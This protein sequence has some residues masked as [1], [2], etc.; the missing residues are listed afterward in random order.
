[1]STNQLVFDGQPFQIPRRSL[2]ARCELFL[3]KPNLFS[4]PYQVRSQASETSFRVFLVEMEGART[5]I[6]M[7]NVLDLD[8]LTK[9][10]Q[11]VELGRQ[12]AE[13]VSQQHHIDVIRL[14][15]A[16]ADLRRRLAEANG[17]LRAE[18]N[19]QLEALRGAIG[20]IEKKQ[21]HEHKN[22][23]GLREAVGKV[24]RQM[25]QTEEALKSAA[26]GLAETKDRKSRVQS[27]VVGL[28]EGMADDNATVEEVQRQVAGLKAQVSECRPNV[29]KD[30]ANLEPELA[31]LKEEMQ[32]LRG[33]KAAMADQRQR[34]AQ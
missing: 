17:R 32:K 25:N 1:M 30:L 11:F 34:H 10:F 28:R 3:E 13:F 33:V 7:G 6:A 27:D 19:S 12:V 2:V 15:S 5:E 22:V 23:S 14:Q 8:A 24:P 20:E 9:E 26:L 29:K 16:I 21:R 31:K 4:T 18:P